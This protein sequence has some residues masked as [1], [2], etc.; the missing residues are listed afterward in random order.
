M[1][2]FIVTTCIFNNCEIRKN[3]YI[4]AIQTLKNTINNN[5]IK[6]CEIIIVENNGVRNTYLDELGCKVYYTH[7]NLST[8]EKGYKELQ[9]VFDCIE[10]YKIKDTDFVVKMTGRYILHE[11]SEFMNVVKN[12]NTTNYDCIIKY[13]SFGLPLD[14]KT[15]DCITGLIGMRCYY[16]KQIEKPKENEVVE[17]KWANVTFLIKDEKIY[18]VN[19]L[20]IY[21][22]PGSNDYY[23]V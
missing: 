4:N 22:C 14:Y 19:K 5:G 9:D 16:I 11:N 17:W 8:H 7:N 23:F 12:I 3:Q 20:G 18:K 13:G 10:E 2:Y 1:I 6:D 21:I 15:N